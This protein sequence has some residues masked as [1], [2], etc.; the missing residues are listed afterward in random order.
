MQFK[1]KAVRVDGSQTEGL[2]EASDKL[3]L[4][5][6]KRKEGLTVITAELV[7]EKKA[8][9][10]SLS[11]FN[12][13][14]IKEKIMF[15]SNL[16]SMISAGLS[17]SRALDVLERQ[18]T[19]KHF[20]QVI[21]QVS[22]KVNAGE[23]F[24]V[25]LASF[26]DIFPEVFVSMVAAGEESG[27]LPDALNIVKEQ[28]SKTY[29]L[30][31]KVRGAMIYPSIIISL[32]VVIAILMMVFMVP[33]LTATF[34]EVNMK[35]PF[36]TRV[37]IAISDF[38][39]AHY[40]I[41]IAAVI[42]VVTAGFI[43]F[44]TVTGRR[45]FNFTTLHLP[46]IGNLTQQTNSAV[47]MRTISSLISSGVSMVDTIKITE[48]VVQNVY[49]KEVLGKSVEKIQMGVA[50]SDIFKDEGKLFPI[51]VGELILVGE[52]TGNLPEMLLK[53]AQFF[54]DEVDQSTK[55]LSTIIEP[56][57]MIIIGIA[58]GF[59]VMALLA[60]MYSLTGSL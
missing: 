24:S 5:R 43:F 29:D 23:G 47:T 22:E 34:K 50:L 11:F 2:A 18:T 25:A 16:S 36:L 7:G 26:P 14:K 51:L 17:L 42:S 31:R 57:L 21:G 32:M 40:L 56:L 52:E 12:G 8:S 9:V 38:M 1:Y 37:V 6:E 35:L 4:A 45:T 13:V 44:R 48:K 3:T 39:T 58:V 59:F 60:P 54:E 41:V 10:L 15:A 49:Y 27:N 20:K 55:N 33:T 30:Q 19:N 46:V 28:L 53:G